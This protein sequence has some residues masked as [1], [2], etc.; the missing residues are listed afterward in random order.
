MDIF[1]IIKNAKISGQVMSNLQTPIDELGKQSYRSKSNAPRTE[2]FV[3]PHFSVNCNKRFYVSDVS[4]TYKHFIDTKY[5]SSN[6]K[7]AKI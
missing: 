3:R 6:Q 7:H 1:N 4:N 5:T 2:F